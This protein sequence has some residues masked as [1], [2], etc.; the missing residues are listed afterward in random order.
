VRGDGDNGALTDHRDLVAPVLALAGWCGFAWYI[1]WQ[2][3]VGQPVIWTDSMSYATV[4]ANPV[5]STGFWAG[6][7]PPLVPLVLKLAGSAT[8]FTALQSVLAVGAWGF[9]AFTVGRLV[10]EGWRRVVAVWIVLGFATTTPI[11]LW[12]RSVL[13]ESLSLSLL[14]LLVAATIWAV[15]GLTWP[16]VTALGFVALLFAATRDAQVWTVAALGVIVAVVALARW[17]RNRPSSLRIVAL[18]VSLLLVAG[19]TGWVVVHTGRSRQN[20]ANALY[21]RIFPFPSRVAWFAAHGMPYARA[22]DRSM[23]DTKPP[24]PGAAKVFN[25]SDPKLASL[26][27]PLEQWIVNHGQSTYLLWLVTHPAYVFTEPLQRPERSFNFDNGLLT[28]YAAPDRVDSPASPV[29]WPAWWWLL[30]LTVIGL[31]TAAVRGGWRERSFQAVVMLG[32]LGIFTML[33]AWHGDGQEVTRHTIEGFA[34]LRTSVL[35]LAVV[36]VLRIVPPRRR[37][38]RNDPERNDPGPDLPESEPVAH[39][40]DGSVVSEVAA[41]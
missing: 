22:I 37:P 10:P 17:R 14:A 28:F 30:P 36:G 2:G 24:T 21:V 16:R 19:V 39:R 11:T 6:Q 41:H 4:A 15:R 7:R 27:A 3:T 33:V 12:N 40:D 31:G 20:V 26:E 9:L 23:A 32:A 13:S 5:W 35:I 18:A 34:E 25:T 29:L 1:F 8:G 38:E